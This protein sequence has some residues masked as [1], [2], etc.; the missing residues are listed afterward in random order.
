MTVPIR[1]VEVVGADVP[2]PTALAN[3]LDPHEKARIRVA[4]HRAKQLYPPP[5]ARLIERELMTWEE[6]GHRLD[7][8]GEVAALVHHL[9]T[10]PLPTGGP[11]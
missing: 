3:R 11:P 7:M 4:V 1:L 6:F 10:A 5:V 8:R 2:P 9:T